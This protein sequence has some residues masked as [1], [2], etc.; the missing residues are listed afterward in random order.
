ML[1]AQRQKIDK[2]DAQL[3]ELFQERLAVSE[4][5]A[6]TKYAQHIGLTDRGREAVLLETL[7]NAVTNDAYKPYIKDLFRDI[8]LISKQLQ[9]NK[10][11]Q[12]QDQNKA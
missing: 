7:T 4:S 11:K 1:E 10:I 5:I 8:L 12:L 3:V 6:E 9:A 2:I